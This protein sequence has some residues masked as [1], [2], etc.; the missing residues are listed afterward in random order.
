M[1]TNLSFEGASF[2][3]QADL[4]NVELIAQ[5]TVGGEPVSKARARFTNYRSPARAYTPEKTRR[6]EEMVAKAF[7]EACPRH[8]PDDI[9]EYGLACVFFAGTNQRRDVD[10]MLKLVSDGLNGVAWADDVQVREVMGRR[11]IDERANARTEVLV[12]RLGERQYLKRPCAQCG[13]PFRTYNSWAT[14]K[15]YCSPECRAESRRAARRAV[16]VHC[17]ADF[18]LPHKGHEKKTC[19]EACRA[20]ADNERLECAQ[21][22]AAF[23]RPKSW[24]PKGESA[25]LCSHPCQV[26][27]WEA[28]RTSNPKGACVDCGGPVSRREYSRC[29]SCSVK[30]R[31][32]R[33]RDL[34]KE[35]L[36]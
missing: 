16:C 19:S 21:C 6:G 13:E 2:Y 25:A 15:K 22:G 28:R 27:Y 29:R 11:G 31:G 3:R 23:L 26:A 10:N 7:R 36:P 33:S 24:S 35:V 12:Y 1:T 30:A 5:F 8:K 9:Y 32:P 17:G 14:S 20:A 34:T 18:C 4:A